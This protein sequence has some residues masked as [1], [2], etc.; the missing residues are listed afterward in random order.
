MT[1]KI[2]AA[3]KGLDVN[4]DQH[5][6][7][8]GAPRIDTIKVLTGNPALTRED[9][10]AALPGFSRAT[11]PNFAEQGAS[12]TAPVVTDAALQQ[13]A[14]TAPQAPEQP[15]LEPKG[16]G[17]DTELLTELPLSAEAPR[18]SRSH[19]MPDVSEMDL[20]EAREYMAE[21]IQVRAQIQQAIPD[22][23][24]RIAFLEGEASKATGESS[25]NPIRAYLD[26]QQ[27]LS[28]Q[29]ADLRRTVEETGVDLKR[30]T[31]SLQGSP[32]D[33]ALGSRP[34]APRQPK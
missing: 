12:G 10:N 23:Q 9:V 30:L 8:D 24:N 15:T 32:I 1:D 11:A 6:T 22:A 26:S 21:L 2:V 19:A 16:D 33:V 29:R 14:G 7:T 28:Q 3:L 31:K 17:L 27:R 34:R 25:D 5:W 4:N 18:C 13:A 20:E